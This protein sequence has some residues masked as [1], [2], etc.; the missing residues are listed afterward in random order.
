MSEGN[1]VIWRLR[2]RADKRFK[3]GHPWVYSNELA[4]SPKGITPGEPVELR[5]AHGNF[6]AFGYGNP[7]SLITF[8]ELT[9]NQVESNAGSIEAVSKALVR[10]G[11]LRARLGLMPFSHRLCFGEAD[12][13]PGL[14]IDRYRLE[15]SQVFVVQAHTAG[16]NR[17]MPDIEKILCNYVDAASSLYGDELRWNETAVMTRN[18]LSVRKLEGL[19]EEKPILLKATDGIDM[20]GLEHIKIRIKPSCHEMYSGGQSEIWLFTNLASGQKT[21]FFLDQAANIEMVMNKLICSSWQAEHKSHT[22]KILDL[23]CYTGQWG[24]RVGGMCR[25]FGLSTE[26]LAVDASSMAL[27]IAYKN[28]IAFGANC[29]VQR[30][31]VLKDLYSLPDRAFDIVISDPPAFIKS[32]K[33]I[34]VGKHAYLQ[35]N[36]QVMRVVKAGGM[37]ISSSCSSL[38]S[39]EDFLSVLGKAAYRNQRVVQWIGRGAQAPDHPILAGFQEGRYLKCWVG[40]AKCNNYDC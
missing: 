19:E 21:G 34:H 9:R 8:R 15:H 25:R 28:V 31:D 4:S 13:L 35:L 26:I 29:S 40:F 20:E 7:H 32:G 24:A 2:A 23:C 10:A 36:T 17:W 3:A 22:I 1:K 14:I 30:G 11:G 39:E 38:F 12:N 37:V 18:D 33:D 16:S 27:N 6:M 5:D